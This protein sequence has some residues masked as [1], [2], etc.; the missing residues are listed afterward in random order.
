MDRNYVVKSVEG[1]N[2]F[3][4]DSDVPIPMGTIWTKQQSGGKKYKPRKEKVNQERTIENHI[5]VYRINTTC[6]INTV[7]VF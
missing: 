6:K 3:V 5:A 1:G 4:R 2:I 7:K